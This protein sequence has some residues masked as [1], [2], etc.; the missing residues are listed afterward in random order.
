MG[1]K[2]MKT[3]ERAP[4]TLWMCVSWSRNGWWMTTPFGKRECI[5]ETIALASNSR[6]FT[7]RCNESEPFSFLQDWTSTSYHRSLPLKTLYLQF[8]SCSNEKYLLRIV[9]KIR[10]QM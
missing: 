1:G 5:S 6:I 10:V 8:C 9:L 7:I 3:Q 4:V 2:R